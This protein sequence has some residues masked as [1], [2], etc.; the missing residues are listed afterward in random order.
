MNYLQNDTKDDKRSTLH[1]NLNTLFHLS[2]HALM[3]PKSLS[4]KILRVKKN[5]KTSFKK[6]QMSSYVGCIFAVVTT[7]K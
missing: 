3:K 1:K 6:F 2:G 5:T 4:P 7:T